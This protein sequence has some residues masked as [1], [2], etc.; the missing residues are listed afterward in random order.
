MKKRSALLLLSLLF[1]AFASSGCFGSS[2]EDWKEYRT[3]ELFL[4]H[5]MVHAYVTVESTEIEGS[6]QD[7]GL[8]VKKTILDA[9]PFQEVGSISPAKKRHVSYNMLFSHST[10]GPNYSNMHI[11]EDGY[12]QIDYKKALGPLRSFYF[13]FDPSTKLVDNVERR[14]STVLAGIEEDAEK[15]R[16]EGIVQNM[17]AA[18]IDESTVPVWCTDGSKQYDYLDDGSLLSVIASTSF[19]PKDALVTN[20]VFIYNGGRS[21]LPSR[22]GWSLGLAGDHET[23]AVNYR[24]THRYGGVDTVIIGYSLA[25]A[26]GENLL[27]KAIE[28]GMAK[29]SR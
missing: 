1:V 14:I 25:K 19:T 3:P 24:F 28:A 20:P 4:D 13:T 18:L 27:S 26:D 17:V 7:Y 6:I 29:S 22:D 2:D 16:S 23:A 12:L 15:A 21:Y 10:A 5:S 11:Y 8:E 9:A